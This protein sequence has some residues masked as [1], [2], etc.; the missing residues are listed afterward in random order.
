MKIIVHLEI[1]KFTLSK[2]WLGSPAYAWI[3][4]NPIKYTD[5]I[6][7]QRLD[8]KP[9]INLDESLF[10]KKTTK[11]IEFNSERLAC[12]FLGQTMFI[13]KKYFALVTISDLLTG[14]TKLVADE[15]ANNE[16]EYVI[17]QLY[18]Q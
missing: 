1:Q 11:P 18:A 2:E 12:K 10:I 3:L 6:S 13:L 4:T 5:T 8:K 16:G 9:Y 17:S 7:I 14:E 15:I